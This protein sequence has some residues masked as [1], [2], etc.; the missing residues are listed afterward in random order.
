[1]RQKSV[2]AIV[3]IATLAGCG[4]PAPLAEDV[5][6]EIDASSTVGAINISTD[7][8]E[9]MARAV[10]YHQ[11]LINFCGGDPST[12]SETF[13]EEI[14]VSSLP[15]ETVQRAIDVSMTTLAEFE[16]ADAEYVCTPEMFEE[17]G[18][19]ADEALAKWDAVKGVEQDE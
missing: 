16:G 17:L 18:G 9:E 11:G 10:A 2:G 14:V 13:M 1:M 12:I 5:I 3:L 15:T 4:E 19:L 8:M 6:A 7:Q